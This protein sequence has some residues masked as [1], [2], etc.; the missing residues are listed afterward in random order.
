MTTI[1]PPVVEESTASLPPKPPILADIA[2]V[3]HVL[4]SDAGVE[5]HS[6]LWNPQE[7]L[8]RTG[9][10]ALWVALL[11]GSM[12]FIPVFGVWLRALLALVFLIAAV[13]NLSATVISIVR[14]WQL[15]RVHTLQ[16]LSQ[17]AAHEEALILRL[18]PFPRA[19]LLHVAAT[20]RARDARISQRL[21]LL[22]GPNRAGGMLGALFLTLGILSAGKYLQDAKVTLPFF[23]VQV[24][25]TM[26]LG[27]AATLFLLMIVLLLAGARVSRLS[28]TADLLERVAALQKHLAEEPGTGTQREGRG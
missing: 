14:D 1:P 23:L 13:V 18:L 11:S 19:A 2:A 26:V 12:F 6:A 7:H 8:D 24:T 4:V 21:A 16:E 20:A 10:R 25:S 28:P 15:R 27:V 5:D 3:H 17:I 9:R 22:L